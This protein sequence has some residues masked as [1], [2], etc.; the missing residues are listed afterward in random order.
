[1]S[2]QKDLQIGNDN[3]AH[4]TNVCLELKNLLPQG[5]PWDHFPG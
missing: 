1:M 5:A 2:F 4:E 3:T